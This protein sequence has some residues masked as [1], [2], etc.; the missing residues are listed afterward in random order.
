MA[1]LQD[2]VASWGKTGSCLLGAERHDPCNQGAAL[3]TAV[4]RQDVEK[5]SP[6]ER[7]RLANLCRYV[8]APAAQRNAATREF[9]CGADIMKYE[10]WTPY[11]MFARTV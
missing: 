8:A 7:G 10:A 1:G 6:A 5:L 11:I 2:C 3:L 4:R 9:L